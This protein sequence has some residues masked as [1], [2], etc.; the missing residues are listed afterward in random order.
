MAFCDSNP[1]YNTILVYILFVIIILFIK[2]N[3]VYCHKTKKFKQ[4]GLND[5][6]SLMCFPVLCIMSVIII[7]FVFLIFH[8]IGCY[9]DDK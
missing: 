8:I 3:I 7:Y 6:Q 4:F 5:N 9:L 2:P 1:I